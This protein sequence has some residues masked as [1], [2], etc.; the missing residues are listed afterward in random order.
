[1][2]LIGEVE[3]HDRELYSGFLGPV[4]LLGNTTL[5]VNIRCMKFYNNKAALFIGGGITKGSALK[6]EWEETEMKGQTLLSV[7]LNS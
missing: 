3:K 1:M 7:V 5:Y 2:Q 4:G 6:E